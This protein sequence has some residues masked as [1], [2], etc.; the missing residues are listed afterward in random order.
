MQILRNYIRSILKEQLELEQQTELPSALP[1]A[2][3]SRIPKGEWVLI[4]P[5]SPEFEDAR[6]NLNDLIN[7]AYSGIGG[8][9]KIAGPESLDRYQFWIVQ[10]LDADDM[11]DVTLFGKPDIG[12]NKLGGIGH[13]GS[14]AAKSAY[15]NKSAEIR[16]GGSVGGIGNWWGEVS[17]KAAYAMLSRGAPSIADEAHVRSLLAGDSIVWHGEHPDPNA[18]ALFKAHTGWYTKTFKDGSEHTKII[19]GSPR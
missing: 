15:K 14:G 5:G 8:H 18:P 10:D 2:S 3:R 6:T 9:I 19:V 11:I 1:L 13:D 17:G 12:G 16:S 4:Q 7:T